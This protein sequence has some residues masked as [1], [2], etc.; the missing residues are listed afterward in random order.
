MQNKLNQLEVM[1]NM[2]RLKK[3]QGLKDFAAHR[4]PNYP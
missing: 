4:H 1:K 3:D 2:S